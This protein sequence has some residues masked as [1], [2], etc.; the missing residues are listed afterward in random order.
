MLDSRLIRQAFEELI[1]VFGERASRTISEDLRAQNVHLNDPDL[2]LEKLARGLN[3]V[4]GVEAGSLLIQ[5]VFLELDRMLTPL[6]K[7]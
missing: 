5:H 3:L 6:I 2:T 4:L 1:A 7:E